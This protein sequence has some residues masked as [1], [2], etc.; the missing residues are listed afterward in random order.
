MASCPGRV[1][2]RRC[3]PVS[4][5]FVAVVDIRIMRMLV[6]QGGMMMWMCMRLTAVPFEVVRMLV[7]SVMQMAM[8]VFQR[9]MAVLVL[10]SFSQV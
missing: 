4:S 10:M 8:M 2:G 3:Y 5:M 9:L 6:R 1:G 7:M